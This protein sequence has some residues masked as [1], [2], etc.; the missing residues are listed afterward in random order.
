MHL[1]IMPARSGKHLHGVEANKPQVALSP[2]DEDAR[3]HASCVIRELKE[4]GG[5]DD[6][7]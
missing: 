1:D 5:L 7:D 2:S 3:A 4:V 6:P